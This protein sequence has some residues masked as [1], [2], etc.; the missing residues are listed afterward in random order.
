MPLIGSTL[1]PRG[2]PVDLEDNVEAAEVFSVADEQI[3]SAGGYQQQPFRATVTGAEGAILE[4]VMRDGILD[5]TEKRALMALSDDDQRTPYLA[6]GGLRPVSL[7]LFAKMPDA[8]R[9]LFWTARQANRRLDPAMAR[10]LIGLVTQDGSLS[11]ESAQALCDFCKAWNHLN[12]GKSE[13]RAHRHAEPF[14][15]TFATGDTQ[16]RAMLMSTSSGLAIN[17]DMRDLLQEAIGLRA[18]LG[19]ESTPIPPFQ[20]DAFYRRGVPV[21]A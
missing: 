6:T 18:K 13:L 20:I 15:K 12:D 2:L 1:P 10:E 7:E 8:V 14:L 3:E 9:D 17:L 19:L 5:S 11:P 16:W 21:K 4:T